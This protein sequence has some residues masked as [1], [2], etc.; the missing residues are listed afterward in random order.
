MK[1]G[2]V[3]Y[4]LQSPTFTDIFKDNITGIIGGVGINK[5]RSMIIPI[6]SLEEQERIVDKLEQLLPLCED[7]VE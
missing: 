4:Y 5:L 2:E 1:V 7:L 3:H 6:P